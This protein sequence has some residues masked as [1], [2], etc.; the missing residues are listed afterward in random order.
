M[1]LLASA[2][3][4]PLLASSF[5]SAYPITGDN[6]N[7][8]DGPGT[9]FT[10]LKTYAKGHNVTLTCQT[11]GTNVE[12]NTIW[13]KTTDDCY[14]ADFYVKTGSNDYVTDKCTDAPKPPEGEIPGPIVNDYPYDG[15]CNGNGGI[16]PWWYYRC[17]CTSFVAWRINERLGIKFHNKYLGAPWGDAKTWDEAARN[18]GVPVN[19]TPV[20]G[21]VAVRNSG[22]WGHVAWVTG[23]SGNSVSIEEYNNGGTEKYSKR[24]VPKTDFVYI[25]LKR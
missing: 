19:N 9:S 23:V 21:A 7:C 13:D 12:G 10:V 11:E 15:K 2:A 6:V 16:D 8:R 3:L 17:Q 14:V 20:P 4:F 5:A 18:T 1:K 25:H 22:T 24:T